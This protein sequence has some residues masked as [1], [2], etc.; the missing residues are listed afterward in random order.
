MKTEIKINTLENQMKQ[1][2]EKLDDLD[3]KIDKGFKDLKEELCNYVRR[4]EF[5]TVKSIVY[6][7]VG[8]ILSAFIGGL[9]YLVFK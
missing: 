9:I 1:V 7:M 6:G 8:S 4:E 5:T 2:N 3:V